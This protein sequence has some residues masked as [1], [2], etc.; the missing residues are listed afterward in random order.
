[1]PSPLTIRC[2]C[3]HVVQEQDQEQLLAA[4]HEHVGSTH[5]ELVGRLTDDDLMAMANAS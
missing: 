1:M 5:P 2:E 3:G 4:A